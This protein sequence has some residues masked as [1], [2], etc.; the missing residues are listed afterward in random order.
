MQ[1]WPRQIRQL[2]LFDTEMAND[3]S[4]SPFILRSV[5]LDDV[6]NLEKFSGGVW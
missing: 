2:L 6:P 3:A 1:L 5:T 4:K